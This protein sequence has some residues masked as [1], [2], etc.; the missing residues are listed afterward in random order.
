MNDS[1][2]D[3]QI[4]NVMFFHVVMMHFVFVCFENSFQVPLNDC[5][6]MPATFSAQ[7][8]VLCCSGNM[9]SGNCWGEKI[10]NSSHVLTPR[11][12][13]G[14]KSP[15]AV[16]AAKEHARANRPKVETVYSNQDDIVLNELR[17]EL[18]EGEAVFI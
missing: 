3:E 12:C 1:S 17:Q 6:P 16:K 15:A 9:D 8:C 2:D 5:W 11:E 10:D 18:Q 4:R 7:A 14:E 13:C